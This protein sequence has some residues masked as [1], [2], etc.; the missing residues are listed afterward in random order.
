MN[1]QFGDFLKD[2][3][4]Y[5]A[6]DG[7]AFVQTSKYIQRMVESVD[8][9]L[10]KLGVTDLAGALPAP[11]DALPELKARIEVKL[12]P[13]RGQKPPFDKLPDDDRWLAG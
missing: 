12:L 6:N 1:Q 4:H 5:K 13:I 11:F 10:K 9:M 2:V 3:G 8:L 7:Q